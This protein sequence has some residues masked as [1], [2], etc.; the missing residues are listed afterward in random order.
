MF[1]LPE[2]EYTICIEFIRVTME[3]VSL[4]VVSTSLNINNV[5]TKSFTGYN[6]LWH[7]SPL[8]YIM[9]DLK[10]GAIEGESN[11]RQLY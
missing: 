6:N 7:I 3:S 4:N 1:K 8:E 2:R 5:K 11:Q 10:C 9:V